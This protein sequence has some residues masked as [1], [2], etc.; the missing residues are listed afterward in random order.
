MEVSDA[1]KT[2]YKSNSVTKYITLN[3]PDLNKT[4]PMSQIYY[5]SMSL[6]EAVIDG[7]DIEFVGCISSCFKIKVNNVSDEL[8]NQK[9]IATI[10]T[11]GTEDE[12]INLFTG[13]VDSAVKQ[14]DKRIKEITAYDALYTKGNTD[15][16]YWYNTQSFPMTVKDFRD[17]LFERIGITQVETDL[18]NDEIIVTKDYAPSSLNAIS[19]I[20]AVCQLNGVCGII[21]RDGNFEYRKLTTGETST[22]TLGFYKSVEY[23]DY[24]IKPV[25]KIMV[26]DTED[27]EGVTYGDGE[28]TYIVQGNIFI[29]GKTDEQKLSIAENI[30]NNV[31]GISFCPFSTNNNGLPYIEC[32]VDTLTYSVLD[33]DGTSFVD[34]SFIPMSRTLSG[35]Q[36]LRD[37]YVA[38]GEEYQSE[39]IT[40]IQ[41]QIDSIKQI[42]KTDVENLELVT[43]TYSNASAISLSDTEKTLIDIT[44]ATSATCVM[45]FIA[46]IPFTA[47]LDGNIVLRYYLNG[48]LME[49]DTLTQYIQRGSNFLTISNYFGVAENSNGTV[50]VKGYMEYF[51]S[52]KRQQDAKISGLVDYTSSGTYTE[53]D[54]DTTIPGATIELGA[55]KAVMFAQGL[56][57]EDEWNG[58]IEIS[59]TFT[60][61]TAINPVNVISLTDSATVTFPD[62]NSNA[63]T[64]TFTAITLG[65]IVTFNPTELTDSISISHVIDNY[66]FETASANKYTYDADYVLI[67]T[68][69]TLR[70]EYDYKGTDETIDDGF[71]KSIT[72]DNSIYA[73]VTEIEVK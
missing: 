2:A 28:N 49:S 68:A 12:P 19:L 62:V 56:A 27:D 11:T 29:T 17:S 18:A 20:K 23:E 44:W 42:T 10:Y 41:L 34:K 55:I 38:E 65:D 26:R 33:D 35:I 43:Y 52:D 13:Y 15:V 40:D 30:Y 57:G 45:T 67:D 1:V 36:D 64:D 46:T 66:T 53:A 24:T 48:V 22:E 7:A 61:I 51:E 70:T 9:I 8:K 14:S 5:E 47:T 54:I 3:F 39:F 4:I 60:P 37:E 73:D 50:A 69:F 63:V 32:G 72:V 16:A 21:N 6:Q 31:S 25:D 71:M 59:E 58:R